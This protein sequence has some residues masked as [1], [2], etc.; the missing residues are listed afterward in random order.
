M[1]YS[2]RVGAGVV[3][4]ALALCA[5]LIVSGR[6]QAEAEAGAAANPAAIDA[7][8]GTQIR[9][10][11]VTVLSTMLADEGIGEWGFATLVEADGK[12]VLVDTGARPQTVLQNARELNVDLSGVKEV[13]LTHNHSDHVGGLMTLRKELMKTNASALSRAHVAKGIFYSRPSEKG[14]EENEMVAIQKEYEATGGTFIEHDSAAEIFP[15]AWLTGP[16]PRE[17]P[18]RNWSV[19]GKV[20]TPAG[21]V[22]DTIPEDQSL[23]LNTPQGL[24]LISGCG[25]AGV[26]N[27]ITFA[28]AAFAKAP[29]LAILGGFHLFAASDAQLDWT[30]DKLKEAGVAYVLGAHCTGI[31]SVYRIRQRLAL[32]R[33]SAVVGA[34]GA[35][36]VLGEGIHPGRIAQ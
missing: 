24:V 13:V 28:R 27:T 26:I 31:E 30:A 3:S 1:R 23:V 36:F 21:L 15:G 19:T 7:V 5:A 29:V 18:E 33:R 22:E 10:L 9:A 34:V 16:V 11:K 17:F 25:H 20:R 14:T 6:S 8:S 32:P 35:T 12:R 4:G 2:F